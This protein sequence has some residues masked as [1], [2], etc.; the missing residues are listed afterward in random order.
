MRELQFQKQEVNF[1]GRRGSMSSG[2]SSLEGMFSCSH[3]GR[4]GIGVE[5]TD[6][7]DG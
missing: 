3:L 6:G 7:W 5:K 4:L 1:R 2:P